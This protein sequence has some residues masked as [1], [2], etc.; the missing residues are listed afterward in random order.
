M[1]SNFLVNNFDIVT[2]LRLVLC[3]QNIVNTDIEATTLT[4]DDVLDMESHCAQRKNSAIWHHHQTTVIKPMQ[5]IKLYDKLEFK[6]KNITVNDDLI[7]RL[8]GILDVNSFDVRTPNSVVCIE[9]EHVFAINLSS[10]SL[11]IIRNFRNF[12]HEDCIRRQL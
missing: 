11:F 2:P 8:I 6:Q 12:L 4:L 1:P 9:H 3:L 5:Q 10:H 7:H